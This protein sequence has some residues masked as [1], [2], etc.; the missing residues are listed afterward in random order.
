ML[1]VCDLPMEPVLY[2]VK[3]YLF[4]RTSPS[5]V[6]EYLFWIKATE[7]WYVKCAWLAP[8]VFANSEFFVLDFLGGGYMVVWMLST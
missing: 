3:L 2:F 1:N 5:V 4:H 8:F 7:L 6:L